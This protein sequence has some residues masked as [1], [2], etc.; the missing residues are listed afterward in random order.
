MVLFWND[1]MPHGLFGAA[2]GPIHGQCDDRQPKSS[3]CGI[4]I[5]LNYEQ[6]TKRP[7]VAIPELKAIIQFVQQGNGSIKI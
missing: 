5:K 1:R 7:K 6:E 2:I 4:G 3:L